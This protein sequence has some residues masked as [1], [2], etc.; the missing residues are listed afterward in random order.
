MADHISILSWRRNSYDTRIGDN[1]VP[2]FPSSSSLRS[3]NSSS[4][5]IVNAKSRTASTRQTEN[6]LENQGGTLKKI[7]K[8]G[9]CH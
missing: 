5:D 6:L 3:R 8:I 1:M 2:V 4:S 9:K 7:H